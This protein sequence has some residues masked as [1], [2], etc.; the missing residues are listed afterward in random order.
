MTAEQTTC[1]VEVEN[2][3]FRYAGAEKN[4]LNGVS[5]R[6]SEGEVLAI[7]GLSGSGKSTLCYCIAG[8][9]PRLVKGRIKG[10]VRIFSED[11]SKLKTA[12]VAT[13]L[14]IVFQEPDDQLFSPTIEDEV[15][16]GPENLCLPREEIGRRIG[17]ALESVG[18]AEYRMGNPENLSGGQKQLI[19]LASVLSMRP[20]ILIFDETMSQIDRTGKKRIKDMINKLRAER[21]TILMVEHDFDNMDVAD[22]ILVM[23][24]G[25]LHPYDG[26]L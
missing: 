25:K 3:Y 2:L 5:L 4:V 13:R 1:P 21:K 9:A 16:F 8:L 11:V 14:G 24:G 12:E 15:A 18:M 20:R 26:A 7:A 19:A 23:R 22:R 10:A 17:E 6:V